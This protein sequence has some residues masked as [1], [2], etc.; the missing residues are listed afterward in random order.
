MMDTWDICIVSARSD[1]ETAEKLAESIR[2]YRLPSGV[3]LPQDGADYRRILLDTQETAFDEQVREQ[4]E[5]C[6]FLVFLCSPDGKNSKVLDQRLDY[7]CS[8][9]GRDSLI[10]VIVR[11]EP[12]DSF[13]DNFIERKMVQHILPD[14]RVI[15]RMETIEPIAADLRADTEK[16]KAQ[17]LRYE[18][19]RIVASVL[20]LHPDDLEQ[21]HR[22]RQ[23][24][25][26]VRG[27]SVAAAVVLIISA[28]FIRL[29]IIARNEGKIAEEQ[30]QLSVNTA[31]RTM[32]ELPELFADEPLALEYIN[33][34]IE[35]A[36]SA[37][38]ELGMEGLLGG[39][40][41]GGSS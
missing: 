8:V 9:R 13:P 1:A 24:K 32:T 20:S 12:V 5:N 3:V 16:R 7:F 18:T 11:G 15:E 31:D 26:L 39:A 30:T 36:R 41:S 35:N 37:L 19:V 2:K 28:I 10:A 29:G 21:R 17:L 40:E 4:L 33:E 27:L 38:A 25:V 14:H 34:A 23:K 6:R 22:A